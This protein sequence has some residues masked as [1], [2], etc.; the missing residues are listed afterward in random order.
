V[1]IIFLY[2]ILVGILF[3]A[4]LGILKIGET[5]KAPID[6]SGKW[7]VNNEFA[8]EISSSCTPV[9]L[10]IKNPGFLIDQSGIHLTLIFNDA[11]KTEMH[12]I[13]EKD[14]IFFSNNFTLSQGNFKGQDR[15]A[16]V[17][18]SVDV[19]QHGGNVYQLKGAWLTP[20]CGNNDII[21]FSAVR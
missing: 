21:N 10:P 13:L 2:I 6:V 11:A 12:G 9:Y 5:I 1:K 16:Q 3:V 8:K 4:L 7:N 15:K 19:L 18:F 17:N 20:N 14:S